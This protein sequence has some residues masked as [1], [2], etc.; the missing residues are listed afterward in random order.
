MEE[1]APRSARRRAGLLG[2]GPPSPPVLAAG[3]REDD[4]VV[5]GGGVAQEDAA[6]A[7]LDVVGMGA[8][9]EDDL[10][11]LRRGVARL[12]AISSSTLASSAAG[13]TGLVM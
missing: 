12:L 3:Q 6:D 4:D 11:A 5:A 7:D 13:S 1:P 2:A 9:R 10:A 8:D